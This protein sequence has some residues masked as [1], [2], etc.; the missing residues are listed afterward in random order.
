MRGHSN[1]QGQR[2]VGITEKPKLVPMDK[3][4]ELFGFEPP[5]EEG[6][7]TVDLVEGLLDGSVRGVISLGGNLARAIPDRERAEEAWR[8]L[9]LNVQVA[10]KLNRSHLLPGKATWL[11]PCLVRDEEDRQATGPQA[12]RSA[13]SS[14]RFMSR[15]VHLPSPT[16]R[17][18]P[19]I[20][21]TWLCRNERAS[22]R[23]SISSP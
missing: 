22:A 6:R 5:Q 15:G 7:S 20:E 2:P 16:R 4:R 23:T 21:R 18:E 9:D 3:L 10:T 8:G 12:V 19:T 13:A 14:A 1:V 11:L 17:S